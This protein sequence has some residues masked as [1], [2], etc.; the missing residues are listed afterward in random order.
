MPP[1]CCRRR[2]PPQAAEIAR[3]AGGVS[4]LVARGRSLLDAGDAALATHIAEWAVRAAPDD[5][6]AQT[7]A[8]D[9]Y[10][11]RLAEAESLMAQGIFRA[12]MND[13]RRALGE[14]P[15]VAPV[16]SMGE[17]RDA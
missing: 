14:A 4:H 2:R 15:D 3:L 13:A 17:E 9:V 12:A 16:L 10:A 1:S 8:R 11:R 7:L 5:R 6:A